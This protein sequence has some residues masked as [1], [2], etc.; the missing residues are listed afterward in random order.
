M[1][2]SNNLIGEVKE[3][4]KEWEISFDI[5]PLGKIGHYARI[6]QVNAGA[7]GTYG[8]R[9]P[10]VGFIQNSFTFQFSSAI[11]NNP[12][13]H[14][15]FRELTI[16]TVTNIVIKQIRTTVDRYVYSI[17]I[18]RTLIFQKLNTNPK[19]FKNVKIYAGPD[20][21]VANAILSNL[22]YRL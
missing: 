3:Q 13:Y 8:D 14:T 5:K 21:V 19:S 22:R 9:N 10:W 18:N 4:H 6:F 15:E 16:N 12:W 7:Y 17:Y 11:D 20:G 1:L 2:K